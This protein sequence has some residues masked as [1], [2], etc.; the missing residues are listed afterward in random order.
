MAN[1]TPRRTKRSYVQDNFHT[2]TGTIENI[3]TDWTKVLLTKSP[4]QGKIIRVKVIVPDSS[5]S[6]LDFK[7]ASDSTVSDIGTLLF[8]KNVPILGSGL[9]SGEEIPYSGSKLYLAAKF[10]AGEGNSLQY[11][12]DI[13]TQGSLSKLVVPVSYYRVVPRYPDAMPPAVDPSNF[14]AQFR[15]FYDLTDQLASQLDGDH[16]DLILNPPAIQQTIMV[17]VNGQVMTH[18]EI[19][20]EDLEMSGDYQIL[21]ENHVRLNFV[22]HEESQIVLMYIDK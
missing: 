6:H 16:V 1:R 5:N 20:G 4:V 21:N 10:Y 11:K 12:I 7:I 22:P 14:P 18:P 19:I 3:G 8:Y 2:I 13:Q 15:K 17:M 9:D